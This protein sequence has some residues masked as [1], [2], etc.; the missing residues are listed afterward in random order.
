MMITHRFQSFG[1]FID[2]VQA[3]AAM[4]D[5]NRA[6][7]NGTAT[8]TGTDSL[9]D[10]VLLAR[11]GWQG[12]TATIERLRLRIDK[13][14]GGSIPVPDIEYDVSGDWLDIGRFLGGEPEY[15]GS[16][17]DFGRRQDA[18]VAK[19]VRVV[20]NIAASQSIGEETMLMRGAAAI[21]LVDTLE[22]HG[23]RCRIDLCHAVS[24]R[25]VKADSLETYVTVKQ[26]GEHLS[27]DKL[28]FL[29]GHRSSCRRLMFAIEEHDSDDVRRQF[30]IGRDMGGYGIPCAAEDKGDVYLDRILSASDWHESLTLAWLKKTLINQGLNLEEK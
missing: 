22:R 8:F 17:V 10:A 24:N 23:I 27:P 12:G 30:G 14:L 7:L 4:A 1:Q 21:V 25:V 5:K 13:M 16:M 11:R 15:F 3:P 28:A 29:L 6:S 2:A 9:A 19:M 18:P 26:E 20:V